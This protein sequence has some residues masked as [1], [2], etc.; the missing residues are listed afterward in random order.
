MANSPRRPV[1][2]LEVT[3]LDSMLS[4]IWMLLCVVVIIVLAYLFTRYV[5]GRRGLGG[6]G[7]PGGTGRFKALAR[8]SLGREQSAVL[9]QAGERYLLLGVAPSGVTLLAELSQEEAQELYAPSPGQPAPP[10]LW[11]GPARRTQA[12]ETEVRMGCRPTA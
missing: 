2:A 11:G 7:A 1:L 3:A 5:A 9:V 10:H 8:L 4:L 6:F 12:K